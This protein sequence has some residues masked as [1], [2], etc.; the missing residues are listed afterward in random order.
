MKTEFMAAITQLSSERNL[1]REVI[2]DALEAALVSAYKKEV[3]SAEQDVAV[4]IDT[5]TGDIRV[6][7]V[8]TV[9]DPVT[10]SDKEISQAEAL[11]EY[12]FASGPQP[13]MIYF[14]SRGRTIQAFPS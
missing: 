10:D 12:G 4:K 14:P 2:L 1:P 6:Y 11:R 13:M 8:K 9:A 3:F 7:L 5:V